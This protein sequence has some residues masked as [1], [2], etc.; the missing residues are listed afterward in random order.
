MADRN[1]YV[2]GVPLTEGASFYG[3]QEFFKFIEDVLDAAKQNVIVLYGQR[4]IGKTSVLHRAAKWLEDQGRFFPV[5]YDLQGK[6]RLSLGAVLEN[7]AQTLAR[8][9]DLPRPDPRQFDDDGRYFGNEFLSQAF[10]RL[11]NTRLVLLID[12]FDVL[13]DELESAR[14]ASQTLF[15]YLQDLIVTRP[16]I[17]FVFVVGRRIEELATHFQAIFKQAVYRRVGHLRPEDSRELIV[18]PARGAIAFSDDAVLAIQSLAAGHPYFTQLICFEAFNAAKDGNRT[19]TPELVEVAVSRAI[20]SGHGALNWFWEGLPR[21]ERFILSAVAQASDATGVASKDAVRRLLEEHRILLSGLELKDAPDRLVEW[22]ML[23]REGPEAYRFVVEI[24]RRWVVAEH[25]LSSARRDIDYVSKRAVRLFENARDA[26]SEGELPYARDEYRR[27]LKA[28]PNHSGAQLGLALVLFELG[29]VDEAIV[30]FQR[31]YAID[32]MSARDGLIRARLAKAKTLEEQNQLDDAVAQYEQVLQLASAEETAVARLG[33]VWQLRAE[34]ALAAKDLSGAESAYRAMLRYDER[35]ETRVRMQKSL[36]AHVAERAAGGEI[37]AAVTVYT[38]LTEIAADPEEVRVSAAAFGLRVGEK[39]R[40]R[41]RVEDAAVF[42]EKIHTLFPGDPQLVDRLD[43]ARKEVEERRNVDRIFDEALAAHRAGDMQRAREGYKKLVQL[44][45]L[46]YKGNNIASL[47]ADT[48]TPAKVEPRPEPKP[49]TVPQLE[50]P[51]LE[52]PQPYWRRPLRPMQIVS[53]GCAGIVM[54]FAGLFLLAY[55][56]AP[57]RMTAI[58]LPPTSTVH[59][60]DTLQLSPTPVYDADWRD[61]PSAPGDSDYSWRSSDE[62]VATVSSYGIVTGV[63]P[64]QTR[65]IASYGG[66][67][68]GT[69][70]TVVDWDIPPIKANVTNILFFRASTSEVPKVGER[71][72]ETQ[73]AAADGGSIHAELNVDVPQTISER[74]LRTIVSYVL[75]RS[76]GSVV[77]E[78][79]W[80]IRV[81]PTWKEQAWNWSL[82]PGKGLAPDTYRIEFRYE[83]KPI[84]SGTFTV[85]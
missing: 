17:G 75:T 22:E 62:S 34:A 8:R 64:G 46:S 70:V 3:R 73:F 19:V 20:E 82:D 57:A 47:L 74:E 13:S 2:I 69:D 66:V 21:A 23:S 85:V 51:Q 29:E 53:W 54:A 77:L 28:N 78:S 11:G 83:N 10:Q 56:I 50:K 35:P 39:L 45:V 24:V 9:I 12:E 84:G 52:K 18:E 68:A 15:P 43:V 58:D 60:S 59:A 25:P 4:R 48:V 16:Q 5:Y 31:A 61:K 30:E 72:Y 40:T 44:D 1:P 26:H 42:Y 36:L 76:D 33:A 55:L 37:N 67:T 14:A 27:T 71:K 79:S 6:E 7:L 80:S 63:R 32:E 81:E 41:G 49:P 65:I 38:L